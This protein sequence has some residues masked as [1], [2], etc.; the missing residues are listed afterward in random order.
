MSNEVQCS[1]CGRMVEFLVDD[2]VCE[3]CFHS[4]EE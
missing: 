4:N 3:R 2:G 1:N